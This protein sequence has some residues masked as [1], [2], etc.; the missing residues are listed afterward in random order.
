MNVQGFVPPEEVHY[1]VQDSVRKGNDF[2]L[3]DIEM[4]G[5]PREAL[6]DEPRSL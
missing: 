5:K 1:A 6:H 4:L 2:E 3:G